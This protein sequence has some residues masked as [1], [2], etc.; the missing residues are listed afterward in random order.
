MFSVGSWPKRPRLARHHRRR[1]SVLTRCDN[2]GWR[3]AVDSEVFGLYLISIY[4]NETVRS[5]IESIF[6]SV[7]VVFSFSCSNTLWQGCRFNTEGSRS[8]PLTAQIAALLLHASTTCLVTGKIEVVVANVVVVY[9]RKLH[10]A[11][12]LVLFTEDRVSNCFWHLY[13]QLMNIDR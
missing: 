8:S 4:R 9:K 13:L 1:G 12:I 6:N 3:R 5:F 11:T 10:E 7:P 2:V